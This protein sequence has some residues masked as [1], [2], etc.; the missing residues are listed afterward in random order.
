MTTESRASALRAETES[1]PVWILP[2]LSHAGNRQVL[3]SWL[4]QHG[5]Y[6]TVSDD[7]AG[8]ADADFDNGPGIPPDRRDAV[9]GRTDQGLDH[10]AAGLGFHLVDTLVSQYGGTLRISESDAVEIALP[11][12][13]PESEEAADGA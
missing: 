12:A 7:H 4:Q 1:S 11:K 9:L 10:P 2:E 13:V 6:E 3:V 8:L 5:R